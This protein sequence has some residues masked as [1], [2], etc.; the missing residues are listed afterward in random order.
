MSYIKLKSVEA[1]N[2]IHSYNIINK[3]IEKYVNK[4]ILNLQNIKSLLLSSNLA[5]NNNRNRSNLQIRSITPLFNTNIDTINNIAN[6]SRL[7]LTDII[8]PN[9]VI[10]NNIENKI[11]ILA[12]K[13]VQPNQILYNLY[14]AGDTYILN[15]INLL[16][17]SHKCHFIASILIL[18]VTCMT[19]LGEYLIRINTHDSSNNTTPIKLTFYLIYYLIIILNVPL[20]Y[21]KYVEIKKLQDIIKHITI[22]NISCNLCYYAKSNQPGKSGFNGLLSLKHGGS[23]IHYYNYISHT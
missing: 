4:P 9:N 20:I 17:Y 5:N 2:Y 15:Q 3:F 21:F 14:N 18:F 8:Q 10:L 13:Y 16:R 23:H 7:R 11:D 22:F 12:N 1:S 6:T 19:I